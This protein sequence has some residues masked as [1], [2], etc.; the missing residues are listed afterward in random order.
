MNNPLFVELING[1]VKSLY[2]YKAYCM[3]KLFL[4]LWVVSV[5]LLCI[6]CSKEENDVSPEDEIKGVNVTE[7]EKGDDLRNKLLVDGRQW[8]EENKRKCF[9]F[10]LDEAEN[11]SR[12]Y[13]EGI[14]YANEA[15]FHDPLTTGGGFVLI[16][17]HNA[18][19]VC[20]YGKDDLNAI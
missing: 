6:E 9:I 18:D 20:V 5:S 7:K 12:E 3:K 2:K 14:G 11:M 19:C 8:D 1:Y 15:F 13:V 17:C 10:D 4:T 16:C